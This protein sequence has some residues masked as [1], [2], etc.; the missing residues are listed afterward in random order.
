MNAAVGKEVVNSLRFELNRQDHE[1]IIIGHGWG[2]HGIG[3]CQYGAK[4]L[5]ELGQSSSEILHYYYPNT[6]IGL[7]PTTLNF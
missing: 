3:L 4:R 7:L 2:Y 5:G 1:W 6:E